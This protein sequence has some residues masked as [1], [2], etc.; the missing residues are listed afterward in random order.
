LNRRE[1]LTAGNLHQ[2]GEDIGEKFDRSGMEADRVNQMLT[3]A[4]GFDSKLL[5]EI[6]PLVST[7][8]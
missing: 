8:A 5:K 3:T 1:F 6:R 2:R 7:E 4:Q